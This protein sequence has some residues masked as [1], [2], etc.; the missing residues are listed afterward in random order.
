ME[1]KEDDEWIDFTQG[2]T[3]DT[4]EEAIKKHGI[5]DPNYESDDEFRVSIHKDYQ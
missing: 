4:V 1:T 5:I 2:I 3:K